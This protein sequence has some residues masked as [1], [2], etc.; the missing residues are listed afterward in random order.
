V[1][2]RV[3]RMKLSS[4]RSCVLRLIISIKKPE[5]DDEEAK[6]RMND[7]MRGLICGTS[8]DNPFDIDDTA[9]EEEILP[10]KITSHSEITPTTNVI[11]SVFNVTCKV[12][13]TLHSSPIPM[14]CESCNNVLEPEKFERKTWICKASGC[15]GIGIGYANPVDVARCGLCGAKAGHYLSILTNTK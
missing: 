3:K 2:L 8:R 13:T 14:C 15:Q 12:C 7:E 4:M 6:R 5:D 9:S 1:K 11:P 10:P